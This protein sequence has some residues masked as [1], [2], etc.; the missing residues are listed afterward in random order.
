[1][2]CESCNKSLKRKDLISTEAGLVC[3]KCMDKSLGVN[4]CKVCGQEF[5]KWRFCMNCGQ[6]NMSY[7]SQDEIK[8]EDMPNNNRSW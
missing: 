7:S 2:R 3:R 5:A 6:I 1:M 8:S 4:R